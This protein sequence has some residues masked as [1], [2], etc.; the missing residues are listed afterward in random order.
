MADLLPLKR[1]KQNNNKEENKAFKVLLHQS[2]C[3]ASVYICI[4][5]ESPLDCNTQS[6]YMSANLLQS[7][8]TLWGL[9]DCSPPGSS[10]HGIFQA[11]TGAGCHYLFQGIFLVQGLNP[12]LLCLLHWQAGSLPLASPR[13]LSPEHTQQQMAFSSYVNHVNR[14]NNVIFNNKI[15]HILAYVWNSELSLLCGNKIHS[16]LLSLCFHTNYK[17]IDL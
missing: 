6:M 11:R 1:Q 13:K 4:C 12:C 14:M 8:P 2:P 10:V 15:A 16:E 3:P 9:M 7:Y 5:E 17:S